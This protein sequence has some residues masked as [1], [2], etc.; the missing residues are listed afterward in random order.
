MTPRQL[1]SLIMGEKPKKWKYGQ[2]ERVTNVDDY[3][4]EVKLTINLSGQQYD[5]KIKWL[6]SDLDDQQANLDN[7]PDAQ[8]YLYTNIQLGRIEFPGFDHL[9]EVKGYQEGQEVE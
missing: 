8:Q 1:A 7:D 2:F 9:I 4:Q 6:L 3:Y 5:A